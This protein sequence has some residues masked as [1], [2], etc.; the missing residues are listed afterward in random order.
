MEEEALPKRRGA[1]ID[2]TDEFPESSF[3]VENSGEE[4]DQNKIHDYNK[5]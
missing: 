2:E 3:I 4:I 5:I 1:V